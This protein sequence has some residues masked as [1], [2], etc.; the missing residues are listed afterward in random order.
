MTL[1]TGQPGGAL[2][3]TGDSA[4]HNPGFGRTK[5]TLTLDPSIRD[6]AARSLAELDSPSSL[7]ESFALTEVEQ[8]REV[9]LEP[10]IRN[11][12]AA[13]ATRKVDDGEIVVLVDL[14]EHPLGAMVE[15]VPLFQVFRSSSER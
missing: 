2:T 1:I 11:Y 15:E 7:W 14:A 4:E 5:L 6:D 8:F 12:G 3:P 9:W 10:D 13:S